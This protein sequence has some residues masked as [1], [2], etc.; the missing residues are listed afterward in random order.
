MIH[1]GGLRTVRLDQGP[2]G[3]HTRKPTTLLTNIP[4]VEELDGIR[5][6]GEQ[7]S[8]PQSTDQHIQMS[9]GLAGWAP[10][11]VH[12][13]QR[14]IKRIAVEEKRI[15]AL[16]AK[17]KKAAE[18]RRKHCQANHLPYRRDCP[19]CVEAAGRDRPRMPGVLLLEHRHCWP[20]P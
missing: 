4:E 17:D 6:R 7:V 14:A 20:I 8:W 18:E 3:H 11:L 10:G 13:L 15:K 9:K 12:R 5:G 2:L 16:T 19:V 1:R